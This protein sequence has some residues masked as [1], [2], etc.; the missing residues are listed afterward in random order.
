MDVKQ[1]V[2][3]FVYFESLN[4]ADSAERPNA[5]DCANVVT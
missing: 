1:L 5:E 4:K 2:K 3:V